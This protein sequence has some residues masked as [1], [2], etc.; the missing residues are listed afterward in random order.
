V[1]G[2]GR[3]FGFWVLGLGLGLLRVPERDERDLRGGCKCHVLMGTGEKGG[4]SGGVGMW[5]EEAS[6]S[7]AAET[8]DKAAWQHN[9]IPFAKVKNLREREEKGR[10]EGTAGNKE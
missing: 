10:V 2:K 1:R 6:M 9:H 5:V 8:A 3:G 4:V 7:S